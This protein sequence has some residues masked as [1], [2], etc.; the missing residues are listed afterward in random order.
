MANI[1]NLISRRN[2]AVNEV[3]R[4]RTLLDKVYT[5]AAPNMNSWK[6]SGS[7]GQPPQSKGQNLT[8]NLYDLTLEIGTRTFVN[9]LV[10]AIFPQNERWLRFTPG[11]AVEEE[12]Y[13]EAA[14]LVEKLTDKFFDAIDNS[15]FYL[16]IPEALE[17]MA[18]ST[19]CLQINEGDDDEPLVF[20]S[21]PSNSIAYE[22]G[23]DG[24]FR[25]YYRDFVGISVDEI[26][27]FWPDAVI[28][29]EMRRMDSDAKNRPDKKKLHVVEATTYDYKDKDWKTSIF[30][31]NLKELIY[32]VAE[33]EPAF[34][35]FRWNRRA[36]EILGRGPAMDAMPAA[37][38]INE[39]MRDELIAAAF[40]ANPMYMAYTDGVVNMDTFRIHPGAILPVLPTAAGGWPLQPVPNA[41]DVNFG[42]LIVQD[43]RDQINKLLFTN[44]LGP[45]DSPRQTATEAA[46]R[47]RELVENASA[48]FARIKRELQDRMVKR[49]IYILRKRGEWPDV[50]LNGKS[51]AIKYETPLSASRGQKEVEK[52]VLYYQ[53]L[54]GMVGPQMA[55][56]A[57]K[58][59]KLPAYIAQNLETDL[60]LVATEREI[61]QELQA[62]QQAAQ[63][64][65]E[66]AQAEE[67]GAVV[68]P[69]QELGA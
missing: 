1:D 59:T 2:N 69:Q 62:I 45:V 19:G 34:A 40:K 24:S 33:E 48:S 55:M 22:V 20:C 8:A 13:D 6:D 10:N 23:I 36:G 44:P 7:Q 60:E 3:Q 30:E 41:G 5:Y 58:L 35:A 21:V 26:L 39:A 43:L 56:A 32:E 68:P 15:N 9:R 47:M 17:E 37:A 53:T 42:I 12:Y 65:Q 4:W 46:I 64:Q 54:A 63:Q 31:L 18:I 61:I 29:D 49:I 52:L 50:Q 27:S 14:R 11:S 67:P 38:S 16:A 51:V 57:T 28:S 66:A 25:G